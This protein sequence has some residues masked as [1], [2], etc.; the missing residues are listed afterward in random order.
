M[1]NNQDNYVHCG[2]HLERQKIGRSS[3]ENMEIINEFSDNKMIFNEIKKSN[4]GLDL[5][6]LQDRAITAVQS[7]LDQTNYKGNM[8]SSFM[9]SSILGVSFDLPVLN[10]T[11]SEFYKAFSLKKHKKGKYEKYYSNECKQAITALRSLYE[12]KFVYYY[13]RESFDDGTPETSYAK[14]YS[15]LFIETLEVGNDG[16][17]DNK[18]IKSITLTLSPIFIDQV[19]KYHTAKPRGYFNEIKAISPKASKFIY[20]FMDIVLFQGRNNKSGIVRL[21]ENTLGYQLRMNKYIDNKKLSEL[22]KIITKCL[23]MAENINFIS[24]WTYENKLIEIKINYDRVVKVKAKYSRK[25]I[26]L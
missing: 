21:K 8:P 6:V 11:P 12:K 3:K 2:A 18:R 19:Q 22:R 7:L 17:E 24:S 20:R 5:T 10:F 14:Y 16:E 1:E 13:K 15:N 4:V 25:K 26:T 9:D 23:E